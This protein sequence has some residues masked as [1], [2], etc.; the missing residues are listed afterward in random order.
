MNE[1]TFENAKVGDRVWDAH[2]GWG[3]IIKIRIEDDHPIQLEFKSSLSCVYVWY[4]FEGIPYSGYFRT[5]FWDE[6]KF[7][8]PP[9]PRRKVKKVMEGW[10]NMY[11]VGSLSLQFSSKDEA[12]KDKN[13][14]KSLGNKYLG[15]PFFIHHEYEVEE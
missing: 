7:E 9:R 8:A 3:K 14:S 1:T 4:N 12:L 15:E 6:I 13:L 10:Y 11:S 2:Y 5:L